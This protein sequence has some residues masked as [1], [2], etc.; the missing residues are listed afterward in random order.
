MTVAFVVN[1]ILT[2]KPTYTT[3][4]LATRLHRA[5]HKVYLIGVGDLLFLPNDHMGANACRVPDGEYADHNAYLEAMQGDEAVCEQ[6]EAT[7]IDVLMLRNN[8]ADETGSREWAKT[9]GIDFGLY[10]AE[11]GVIVL[12]DPNGLAR[13]M[14]K[15]YFQRF[16]EVVRPR[17]LISRN[18]EEIKAFYE[19]QQDHI[20][21]K[22]LQGS[23]GDGVFMI[24]KDN[25]TNLNQIVETLS[26]KGYIV[27]QEFLPEA[28]KGDIRMF[29]MNGEP[30][31]VNGKYAAF[32]RQG[33]DGDVR[34]NMTVGGKA[35]KADITPEILRMVE[36]VKP[37]LIRDGMF[38]VGLDIVGEKMME[39][40]VLSPGGLFSA[41]ELEGEDFVAEVIAAL[42]RK[43]RARDAYGGKF[44]N[45]F[46]S[47]VV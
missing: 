8:P 26:N 22:P 35:V 41:G 45:R 9:A 18:V 1:D 39:V 30:L 38:L 5:G 47:A 11:Q 16:P 32:L 6:I 17:T 10:A 40:N 20:I 44:V 29:V 12:N 13:A 15:L 27:A 43:V 36:L 4:V 28:S 33:A 42:E 21:L 14:N 25:A 31:I 24:D 37:Q 46:M 34:N 3:T 23:G 19:E 7:D 2:E